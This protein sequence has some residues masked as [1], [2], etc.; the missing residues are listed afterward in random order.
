MRIIDST[1]SPDRLEQRRAELAD[2]L[3]P[4]RP[5]GRVCGETCA[6][7]CPRCGSKACQCQCSDACPE[8]PRAL[9]ADPEKYPIEPGILP[10]VFEMRRL[11]LFAPCWSCEGH[12]GPGEALWKLPRVWFYCDSTTHLRLLAS[13]LRD[14]EIARKLSTRWQIVVTFSDTDNSAT[15]FSLEPEPTAASASGLPALQQDVVVIAGALEGMI[16]RQA[17]TLRREM[18]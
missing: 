16:A 11:G 18:R 7:A 17:A 1:C 15:T 3:S 5:P 10:L 2:A 8:A 14:L 12:L 4:P 13:G 9:S 6:V